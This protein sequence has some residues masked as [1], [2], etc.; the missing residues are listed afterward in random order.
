MIFET[1]Y[2]KGVTSNRREPCVD[3]CRRGGACVH[4]ELRVDV[5]EVL[6][7]GARRSNEDLRYLSIRLA[8][9]QPRE[10]LL[11]AR[12]QPCDVGG[13]DWLLTNE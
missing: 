9:G 8:L 4:A 1:P 3:A 13:F 6:L 10:D 12:S 5:V 7:N 2:G 11:L